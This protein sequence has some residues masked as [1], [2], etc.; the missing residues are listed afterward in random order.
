MENERYFCLKPK[1]TPEVY[2][3]GIKL[4]DGKLEIIAGERSLEELGVSLDSK[5][6]V[7]FNNVRD[8]LNE[9]EKKQAKIM[10]DK[11]WEWKMM[12]GYVATDTYP[13]NHLSNIPGTP[14]FTRSLR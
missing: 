1:S 2:G 7:S 11:Y 13:I 4:T 10:E 5:G 14:E 8:S 9:I 6:E 3:S 12:Q